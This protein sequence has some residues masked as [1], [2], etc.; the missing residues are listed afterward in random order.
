[1]PIFLTGTLAV[2]YRDELAIDEAGLGGLI[3]V[4]AVG[5]MIVSPAM[6][7]LA[8]RLGAGT[9][10]RLASGLSGMVM[11]AV[12]S[13]ANSWEMMA[14]LL[15][16]GGIAG[17]FMQSSTNLWLAKGIDESRMGLAF[18]LKQA[19]GPTAAMLAGF[20]VPTLAM[21]L[22]WRWTFACFGMF[23]FLA[24]CSVPQTGRQGT[25]RLSPSR[26]GDVPLGP[27]LVLTVGVAFGTAV[28]TAFTGFAV[29]AA[30]EQSNMSQ[31]AAGLV[32]ALGAGTGIVTRIGLGRLVDLRLNAGFGLPALL[33]GVGSFGFLFLATGTT[34]AFFIAIPFSFATA[35]GWVG[36]FHLAVTK[37]N[38]NAPAA[39][40][41]ITLVGSHIG[42][43]VGPA[44]F[45]LISRHSFATAWLVTAVA[46]LVG[47]MTLLVAQILIR[48]RIAST[49]YTSARHR[50]L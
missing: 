46:S 10:L 7:R 18:G 40:T 15:L 22:G 29:V 6:G 16:V 21:A 30:V 44:G 3:A 25:G 14:S 26:A 33:V 11:L 9:S 37:V 47:A 41:G 28:S 43:F 1:M 19:G 45:G 39:A 50:D 38:V 23:A 8:E 34:L 20:A 24:A 17:S 49:T 2:Q 36:L 12:A 4:F 48:K 35:W 42:V 5:G 13:F 31:S 27:M 32:F